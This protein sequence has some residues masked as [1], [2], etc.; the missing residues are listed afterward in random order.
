MQYRLPVARTDRHTA[1][2]LHPSRGREAVNAFEILPGYTGTI[3][4]DAL[5]VDDGPSYDSARHALC[6]AHLLRDL[7]AAAEDHPDQIWPGQA[8]DAL[9]ALNTLA[10][11]ARDTDHRSRPGRGRPPDQIHWLD[12]VPGIDPQEWTTRELRHS[13]LSV[14]SDAGVPLEQSRSWSGTAGPASQSSSTVTS[15]GR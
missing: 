10:T 11:I 4:H 13:I 8:R 5:A 15:C 6:G 3:V 14:L 2:F 1:S 9:L 12:Q 7:T